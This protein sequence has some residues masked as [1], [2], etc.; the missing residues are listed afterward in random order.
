MLI[1][2]G[3][4][5]KF[6]LALL[7]SLF[8]FALSAEAGYLDINDRPKAVRDAIAK[9]YLELATSEVKGWSYNGAEKYKMMNI[10]DDAV[11]K[12]IVEAHPEQK[13]FNLLDVGAGDHRWANARVKFLNAEDFAGRD[14]H[15][16]IFSLTGDNYKEDGHVVRAGV[17]VVEQHEGV[18]SLYRLS[19]FPVETIIEKLTELG[20]FETLSMQVDLTVSAYTLFHLVDPVGTFLQLYN[21]A[22]PNSGLIF[23]ENFFRMS[24]HDTALVEDFLSQTQLEFFNRYG[25]NAFVVRRSSEENGK[26]PFNYD[27]EDENVE[28]RATLKNVEQ[29]E[30]PVQPNHNNTLKRNYGDKGSPVLRDWLP[31]NQ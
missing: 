18:C 21:L 26:F 20:Y 4:L 15:F 5:R 24:S 1:R 12:R 6:Y 3:N 28:H 7:S 22:R 25:S 8:I 14:V 27:V 31:Q 13:I 30:A 10:D 23:V 9:K 2:I 16:N 19:A 17:N 29:D 11:V